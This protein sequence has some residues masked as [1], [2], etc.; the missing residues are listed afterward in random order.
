MPYMPYTHVHHVHHYSTNDPV[1]YDYR[2]AS[3]TTSTAQP[4][5]EPIVYDFKPPA[6]NRSSFA[7]SEEIEQTESINSNDYFIAGM[8]SMLFR[9]LVQRKKKKKNKKLIDFSI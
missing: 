5:T 2:N 6:Q 1:Y 4:R 3:A 7:S 9:F 8:D